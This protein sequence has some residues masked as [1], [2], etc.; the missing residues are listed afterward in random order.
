MLQLVHPWLSICIGL[1][2][3]GSLKVGGVE[4]LI[5]HPKGHTGSLAEFFPNAEMNHTK[6]TSYVLYCTVL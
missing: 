2:L 1:S 5:P 6:C 3:Q 4:Y